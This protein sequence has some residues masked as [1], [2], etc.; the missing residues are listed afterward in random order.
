MATKKSAVKDLTNGSPVKLILGFA[1]PLLLGMLF[2]QF[3]SMVDTIIVGKFL[4]A[5]ALA[6]VGSTGS[7]NFMIVGFCMGVCSGFAIPVAQ[8]FGAGDRK[9]LC[10]YVGNGAVLAGI[11]SVVMTVLVCIWCRDI[12]ILMKTPSDIL[13]GAYAYIFVIFLGIPLMVLY[14]Q[15]SAIMRSLG[16]SRSPLIFLGISS[17]LNIV[18]DL[19]LV[20]PMG[21]AGTAWATIIA[22][23][24]S[25]F[26]CLFY[27]K[28][29][30]TILAFTREDWKLHKHYVLNLC[31]MGIPMGLQYSI[32]AIGSVILQTAVNGLGSTAVASVTA[33]GKIS[34]FC[35]CPFDALGSTMA[36]YAGQNV[37]AK[38]MDRVNTGILTSSIIGSVYSVVILGVMFLLVPPDFASLC[39][40]IRDGH[41][42]PGASDAADQHGILHSADP[43]Q[44]RTLY[45]AGHGL[46]QICN[47]CRRLRDD[48]PFGGSLF[49]GSVFWLHRSLLRKPGGMDSRR[50]V[51]RSGVPVLR[52]NASFSF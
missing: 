39:R 45:R 22:Q 10:R 20:R 25:G 34:M 23:G 30:F 5:K 28:K 8:M 51:S 43:C 24:V 19:A 21:V 15:T 31:N 18:L 32:T 3:Y 50:S 7:I 11:L 1:L 36:T 4:G 48:R 33:A 40:C 41:P 47:P 35:C 27:M 49:P 29:K 52:K 9:A 13:D 38:K 44:C 16:D 37:G 17:I 12:L 26:L 14:N 42:R 6:A 46:Q 2:Q